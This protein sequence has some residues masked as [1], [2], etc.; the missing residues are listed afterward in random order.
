MS[1]SHHYSGDKS[2]IERFFAQGEGKAKPSFPDGQISGDDEG[3]LAFAMTIDQKGRLLRV[4]FNKPV[5]WMAFDR[6]SAAKLRDKIDEFLR[7]TAFV[8]G[9]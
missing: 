8:E 4:D 6:D 1:A 2:V 9:T 3:E 5:I 7:E